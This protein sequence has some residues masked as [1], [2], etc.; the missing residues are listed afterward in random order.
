MT[1]E[2]SQ[3][4]RGYVRELSIRKVFDQGIARLDVEL[5][6][7]KEAGESSGKTV[8]RFTD[9]RNVRCGDARE[10]IDVDAHMSLA[11]EDASDSGSDGIRFKAHDIGGG[12]LSLDCRRFDVEEVQAVSFPQHCTVLF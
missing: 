9:A 10:G 2:K 7:S 3:V 1:A 6:L 8:V 4:V 5:S 12:R 11:I